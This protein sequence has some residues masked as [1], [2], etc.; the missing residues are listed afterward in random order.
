MKKIVTSMMIILLL[1]ILAACGAAEETT[2]NGMVVSVN[3]TVLTIAQMDGTPDFSGENGSRPEGFGG[4][5]PESFNAEGFDPGNFAPEGFDG[6]FPDGTAPQRGDGERPDMP[7]GMTRPENGEMPAFGGENGFNFSDALSD[8]E[9]TEID[10]GDAH[11]SMED[12]GAK[13]GAGLSDLKEGSVVTITM[14]GDKVTNV[15]ITSRRSFAGG[16]RS[17]ESGTE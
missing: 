5:D 2:L 12:D 16:F 17:G 6:T 3:G 11:I 7:E 13:V 14:S 10:I 8:M 9:T 1:L 4:F 15:L